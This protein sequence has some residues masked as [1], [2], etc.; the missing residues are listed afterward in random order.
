MHALFITTDNQYGVVHHFIQGMRDDLEILGIQS[1]RVNVLS[2]QS[3]D[4][5]LLPLSQYELVIS[6]NG[7]GLT[8]SVD[9]ESITDYMGKR[10]VFIYTVDHP[11]H[12]LDRFLGKNVVMLCVDQEHVA[13]CQ[14]CGLT[15]V[16]FP[17]AVSKKQYA[18]VKLIEPSEKNDE[19]L[20]PVSFFDEQHWLAKLKPVWDQVGHLIEQANTITRFM[21]F[22]SVLPL[23]DKPA[24][25]T[26]DSN[27]RQVCMFVD[28]Y[29]RA[30]CRREC[31][32]A[33]E[34]AGIALTVIGKESE[35]YNAVSSYHHYLPAIEFES[36]TS[37]IAQAK[38]LVHNTPGFEL[39]LH[40][41]VV[42]PLALGTLVCGYKV[43]HIQQ[44][45]SQSQGVLSTNET[46]HLGL[47]DYKL[48]QISARNEILTKHT[49]LHRWK[50]VLGL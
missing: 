27:I 20:Y 4:Y 36:L 42:E 10:P 48:R 28:Y 7:V 1:H 33:F 38:Y 37:R 9:G 14:L 24:T 19:F 35:K 2:L 8:L 12:F 47:D 17:H 3:T 11:I 45:F 23:G 29:L 43:P 30:K 31:L 6:F 25:V 34:A 15:A 26:L 5:S 49:W 22:L 18:E 21:Q 13:F 40:E 50:E 39:G 41:R 32:Q 46:L 44:E 16:Y